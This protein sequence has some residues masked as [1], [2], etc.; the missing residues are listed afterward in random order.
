[1]LGLNRKNVKLSKYHPGWKKAFNDEKIAIQKKLRKAVLDIEHIGSTSIPGMS[2]KP[3]LDFMIAIK[4][5]DG[6]EKYVKLLKELKYEFRRDNRATQEHVIFVKG[7]E[8]MRTHYLKL[9]KTDSKF[10][11]ENILFRDY[12]INHPKVATEYKE[13][14]EN[15]QESYSSNRATYTEV[16]AEFI[17]KILTLAKAEGDAKC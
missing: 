15:L 8:D 5:I 13:L 7:P 17:Q 1:M 9:T 2:A 3:I 12:L 16:K 6:Y 11:K 10:W 14:K 4:S